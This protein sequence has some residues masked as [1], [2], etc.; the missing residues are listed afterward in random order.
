MHTHTEVCRRASIELELDRYHDTIRDATKCLEL[1]GMARALLFRGDAYYSVNRYDEALADL[2]LYLNTDD[3]DRLLAL[4][5]CGV[6]S[7]G[8][9]R[10]NDA[11]QYFN[12]ALEIDPTD[13]VSIDN[14]GYARYWLGHHELAINDFTNSMPFAREP[15]HQHTNR[16]LALRAL[17]RLDDAKQDFDIAIEGLTRSLESNPSPGGRL[18]SRARA[19][20]GRGRY[21]EAIADLDHVLKTLPD[22]LLAVIERGAVRFESGDMTGSQRDF[23]EAK[24]MSAYGM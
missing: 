7:I 17:G 14:R 5:K 13:A 4:F 2:E 20:R 11:V 6:T 24:R 19:L 23:E 18:L 16:G 21:Q 10:F 8:M 3:P 15:L 9:G 22:Y 1:E 12:R